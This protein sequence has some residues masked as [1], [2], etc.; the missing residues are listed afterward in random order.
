MPK[1]WLFQPGS[2]NGVRTLHR[3]ALLKC[4]WLQTCHVTDMFSSFCHFHVDRV[5]ILIPGGALEHKNGPTSCVCEL[6]VCTKISSF[7][8]PP[9]PSLSRERGLMRSRERG[10]IKLS[11]QQKC[12]DSVLHEARILSR[13]FATAQ[14]P[15]KKGRRSGL[16]QLLSG[17][18]LPYSKSNTSKRVWKE[19]E[20]SIFYVIW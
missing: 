6:C 16:T 1:S 8:P 14:C 2:P 15:D 10:L 4:P 13:H 5:E 17:Y 19:N 7:S 3:A 20:N 12:S 11:D 18:P 9:P